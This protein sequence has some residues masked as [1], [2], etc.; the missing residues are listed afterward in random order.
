L[1]CACDAVLTAN[2]RAVAASKRNKWGDV[3]FIETSWNKVNQSVIGN[4]SRM[5]K[6]HHGVNPVMAFVIA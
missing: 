6:R 1:S 5:A 4:I 3:V 2:S